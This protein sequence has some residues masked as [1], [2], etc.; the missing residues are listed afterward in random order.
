MCDVEHAFDDCSELSIL[1]TSPAVILGQFYSRSRLVVNMINMLL[2][3][4]LKR[5]VCV[6]EFICGL[7]HID[8]GTRHRQSRFCYTKKKMCIYFM[9]DNLNLS[10]DILMLRV[11]EI[12]NIKWHF[13]TEQ[14]CDM[15]IERTD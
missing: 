11:R 4:V 10:V 1:C 6:R 14:H 13:C 12:L 15:H 3:V 7:I 5:C 9:S 8:G 2:V